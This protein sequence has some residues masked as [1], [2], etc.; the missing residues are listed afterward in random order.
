MLQV[1]VYSW[2]N[3]TS[4]ALREVSMRLK[5]TQSQLH[6]TNERTPQK[7]P[8][9]EQYKEL[10]HT[11]QRSPDHREVHQNGTKVA[12]D[13]CPCTSIPRDLQGKFTKFRE[14]FR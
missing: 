2:Q 3:V 7:E 4:F 12:T 1:P 13:C 5:P 9:T 14:Q 6:Y 10:N 11:P 8:Q